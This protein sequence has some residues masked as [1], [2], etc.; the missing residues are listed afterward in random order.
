M[1]II[2]LTTDLGLRDNY[3]A[4]VKGAILKELPET[5]I[6]DIT[7][8]IPLFDF[9]KAAFILK[10]CYQDFPAGSIHIIGVNS[11]TTIKTPHIA[12]YENGHYFIGAD[13]GI[14]SLLFNHQPEKIV[15]LT[16]TQDTNLIA[17]PTKDVFVKAACHIARGGTLE[18]IGNSKK[19]LNVR[20]MFSP[21][22]ENNILKGMAIYID[23]YGNIVTNITK[24]MFNEYGKHRTFSMLFRKAEYEIT[25]ISKSYS[26]VIEGE[27]IALFSST[28]YIEIAMNRAN[29][30]KLFGINLGDTIRIEFYD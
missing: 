7:H 5:T 15:E 10:H 19:E 23:H 14:F 21:I 17:F 26:D 29:A 3:V 16:L 12:I 22:F 9:Q 4:T 30:S 11:E 27:R 6:I 28:G 20:T 25:Q 8:E 24:D 1:A 18:V 13:N 2:T